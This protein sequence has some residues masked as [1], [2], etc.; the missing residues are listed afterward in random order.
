MK[1]A[2]LASERYEMWRSQWLAGT[3][4]QAHATLRWHGLAATLQQTAPAPSGAAT[5]HGHARR[6]AVPPQLDRKF[7]LQEAAQLTRAWLNANG[8]STPA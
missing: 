8:G 2:A 3:R 5:A 1:P 7:V 4:C 6:P